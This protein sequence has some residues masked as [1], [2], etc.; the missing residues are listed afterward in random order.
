MKVLADQREQFVAM[1]TALDKLSDVT[2]DTLNA[3][4]EDIVADFKALEP[5]LRAAGQGGS[6]PAEL[7]A[8][9]C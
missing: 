8:R 7:A 3:S 6:G 2:V 1:L 4:Q 5:I 9:S